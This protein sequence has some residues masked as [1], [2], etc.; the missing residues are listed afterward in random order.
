M[1]SIIS[2]YFGLA[3]IYNTEYNNLGLA[4]CEVKASRVVR[5]K[6]AKANGKFVTWKIDRAS[7]HLSEGHITRQF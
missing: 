7:K 6:F 3:Q 2:V 1:F 4:S 5:V